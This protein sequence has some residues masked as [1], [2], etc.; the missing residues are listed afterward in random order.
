MSTSPQTRFARALLDPSAPVPEGWVAHNGSDPL[1]RFNVYRNNVVVSLMQALRDSFP[2]L[3]AEVGAPS[4]DAWAIDFV[5]QHPPQQP[6][7]AWYGDGFA[8][9]LQ[10][11]LP[12][13]QHW[14]CDLARLEMARI[15]AYHA[16]DIPPSDGAALLALTAEPERL[17]HTQL[18]LRPGV[19]VVRSD[20]PVFN[21]WARQQG[22]PINQRS[23]H[24][25]SVL[26]ARE[27]WDVVVVAI[28][29]GTAEFVRGLQQGLPLGP[30]WEHASTH[31]PTVDLVDALAVL[32]RQGCLSHITPPC[33]GN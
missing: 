19:A 1:P 12:P 17:E 26:V 21:A 30:A 10:A 18:H 22:H 23:A 28:D 11:F 13:A 20:G 15:H 7:L 14:L 2:A 32:I 24:G 31:A 5:R 6:V 9:F 3:A 8:D 16:A 25:Q 4:F 29:T 33:E 27:G